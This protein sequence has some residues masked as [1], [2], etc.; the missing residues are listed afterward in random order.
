M[1][2]CRFQPEW[3]HYSP[4]RVA[5][6]AAVSHAL[7]V[8]STAF[9]FMR[10]EESYKASYANAYPRAWDFHAWS[11]GVLAA[12]GMAYLNGKVKAR[13]IESTALG[14]RLVGAGRNLKASLA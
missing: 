9:D 14:A 8:G 3:A 5:M 6:D 13:E 1:W 7:E 11:N 2:N 12:G 10:G 4:G